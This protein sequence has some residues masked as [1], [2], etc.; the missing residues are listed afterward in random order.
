MKLAQVFSPFARS[1][2]C[3]MWPADIPQH[4]RHVWKDSRKS[5][6]TLWRVP[7]GSE[8]DPLRIELHQRF[9]VLVVRRGVIQLQ[10]GAT[11]IRAVEGDAVAISV[12]E[13]LAEVPNCGDEYSLFDLHLFHRMPTPGKLEGSLGSLVSKLGAQPPGMFPLWNAQTLLI[14]PLPGGLPIDNAMTLLTRLL[15]CGLQSTVQFV[16]SGLDS[17]STISDHQSP[18]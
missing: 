7:M 12:S 17:K 4:E 8:F 1:K 3:A 11:R 15:S 10:H 5:F 6:S 14:A 13:F 9:L 18:P 2:R 16:A